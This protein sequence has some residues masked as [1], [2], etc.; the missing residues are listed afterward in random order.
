[1]RGWLGE[2]RAALH[3]LALVQPAMHRSGHLCQRDVALAEALVERIGIRES[4][5]AQ[6][7]RQRRG[8]HTQPVQ[9]ALEH[10]PPLLAVLRFILLA[11]PATD[12]RTARS[13]SVRTW[14]A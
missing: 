4:K 11:E 6:D 5:V 13:R 8:A 3:L 7:F 12:F 2:S 14:R 9:F 1:M 10:L